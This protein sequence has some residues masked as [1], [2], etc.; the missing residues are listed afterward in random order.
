MIQSSLR[1]EDMSYHFKL[2]APLNTSACTHVSGDLF[3]V[4][5]IPVVSLQGVN[6]HRGITPF[7]VLTESH[8]VLPWI[9]PPPEC[10]SCAMLKKYPFYVPV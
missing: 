10:E 5:V 9:L 8:F 2:K 3:I 6:M 4:M 7:E 1:C